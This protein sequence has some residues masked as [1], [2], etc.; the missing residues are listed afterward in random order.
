MHLDLR[1]ML[2]GE[3]NRIEIDFLLDPE[4]LGGV[5]FPE[6]ARV[7]GEITN[8]G[9]YM[10][11]EASAQIPYRGVC[12]RCLDPVSDVYVLPFERTVVT[13]GTLT[14]E[15]E[16]DNVDEFVIIQGGFLDIDD[17]VREALILS[18]PMRL[19]CSEDCPGLC[20]KC[21]KPKR[22]GSC[23]CSDKEIDPRWAVLASL[24]FD[25][26]DGNE[27]GKS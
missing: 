27:D 7:N 17:A 20:P 5:E 9:G 15:Q 22:E 3:T 12:A 1:P 26:E 4:A 11:L 8:R 6:Q 10:R 13:E 21:G 2:R 16:E 25:E 24:R 14:E 23:G 19:L 18:F